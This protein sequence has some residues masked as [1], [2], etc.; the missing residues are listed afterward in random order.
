MPSTTET[1]FDERSVALAQPVGS[2]RTPIAKSLG[3]TAIAALALTACGGDGEDDEV[4]A[5]SQVDAELDLEVDD[6]ELINE[7]TLTVCSDVP[8]PPFEYYD[9]EGT[10]VGFD[11]DIAEGLASVLDVELEVVQTSF[12][13]IQSGVALNAE[14]CDL[15]ISGMTI[16]EE[17]AGNM[18]FSDPYLDDNL[19]LLAAGDAGI[20]SLEDID[21]SI[22]VGVQADTTGEDYAEEQGY[23][24]RSYPDSGLLIQGLE[25]GQVEAAIGNISILGYQAGEDDSSEFVEEIDTGEQLGIAAQLENQELIDVVDEILAEMESGGYMAEIEDLWF[26][27]GE[28]PD[29]GDSDEGD[30]DEDDADADEDDD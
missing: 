12:E 15:A 26:G 22:N 9:E 8:Y 18:L 24:I 28:T 2:R 27:G 3:V 16:T 1:E 23:Q 14:T 6:V 17:R 7:G 30:S 20:G 11:I 21:D 13:G 25:S 29:E 4:E 10:V 19:G 5:E